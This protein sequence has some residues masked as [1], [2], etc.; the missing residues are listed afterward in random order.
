MNYSMPSKRNRDSGKQK[1]V[2]SP[3][4]KNSSAKPLPKKKK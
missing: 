1:K 3:N 4:K 2:S